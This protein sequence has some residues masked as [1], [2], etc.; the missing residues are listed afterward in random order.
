MWAADH[1][2]ELYS[3]TRKII[4]H[5]ILKYGTGWNRIHWHTRTHISLVITAMHQGYL[6]CVVVPTCHFHCGWIFPANEFNVLVI[7]V[8]LVFHFQAIVPQSDTFFANPTFICSWFSSAIQFPTL[9]EIWQSTMCLSCHTI[10]LWYEIRN[11][12]RE[13]KDP[14][15]VRW[16]TV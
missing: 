9:Q 8:T 15:E 2:F 16:K 4:H 3:Q 10:R 1:K 5:H 7:K 13:E 14:Q 12:K 6:I 11:G